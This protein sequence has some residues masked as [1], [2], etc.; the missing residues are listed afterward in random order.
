VKETIETNSAERVVE[1][2]KM[3]YGG[4]GLARPG[5][6]ALLAPFVL[7]G[8]KV[9]IGIIERSNQ[10]IR[11]R[12]LE[13]LTPSPSRRP[14]PCPYFGA[15]GGCHYQHLADNEQTGVKAGILRETLRRI[16]KFEPPGPVEVISGPPFGYRNRA[17]FHLEGRRI[18]YH[19]MGSS[20]LHAI[21]ECAV[22]SPK[23]QQVHATLRG[24]TRDRRWPQFLRMVEIF[25]N[26]NDVQLNVVRADRPVARRFFDWCAGTIEGYRDG[27]LTYEAAGFRFRVSR[28][29]FF[30]VNRFLT[31]QLV[32]EALKGAGGETALDL[33]SGVGLFALPLASRF[34]SVTAVEAGAAACRDLRFNVRE[35]GL[36]VPAHQ[37]SAESFLESS[38]TKF[39]FAAADPPRSGLGVKV[40]Q[41]LLEL[42]PKHLVVVSCDPATLARDLAI[43]RQGYSIEQ[44]TM[45]DLFPQTFHIETIARLGAV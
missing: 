38:Q 8:E 17:R 44:I 5:G 16:G 20:R 33:Y 7:P 1:F 2:E 28:D 22:C 18:G 3:V 30:Q 29:A 23:L 41:K 35:A 4:D 39:D 11:A 6:Q 25:T 9:R 31:G 24:M 27:A 12:P 37:K 26:E 34:R 43:L 45:I 13:I 42:R 14:A 36:I 15:C 10:L 32:E 21:D 40:A 19:E